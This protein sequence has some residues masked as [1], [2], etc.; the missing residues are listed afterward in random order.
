MNF[1]VTLKIILCFFCAIILHS[2][3]G[4]SKPD[5]FYDEV[6]RKTTR[7]YN[8]DKRQGYAKFYLDSVFQANPTPSSYG[9]FIYYRCKATWAYFEMKTDSNYAYVDSMHQVLEKNHLEQKYPSLYAN[10]LN[11]KGDYYFGQNDLAKSFEYYSQGKVV[12]SRSKDS[13]SMSDQNYHMGMVTYRQEK[14]TDA[15]QHFK[16]AMIFIGPCGQNEFA[17]YRGA[18]L[19]GNIGLAYTHVKNYDSALAYYK[20]AIDLAMSGSR[21]LNT[22]GS[23]KYAVIASGVQYGNMAKVYIAKNMKDSAEQL[24]LKSIVINDRP[25][26]DHIDALYAYMQLAELYFSDKQLPLTVATLNKI[27]D[28][29]IKL[30]DNATRREIRLRWLHLNYLYNKT[31]ADANGAIGYLE[32]YQALKDTADADAKVLKQTDYG[33][34]L[35][36]KEAQY[37]IDLLKRDNA[38]NRIYLFVAIGWVCIILC[39]IGLVYSNYR[40]SKKNVGILTELNS[41]ISQQKNQLEQAMYQLSESNNDKDRI[42]YIVAHDLRNPISAMMSMI[43]FMRED[44]LPDEHDEMLNMMNTAANV[45]MNL[46]N[47]LLQFSSNSMERPAGKKESADINALVANAVSLLKI[48]ADEKKQHISLSLS[49]T[50]APVLTEPEKLSRVFVNVLSNAIKFSMQATTIHISVTCNHN[51]VLIT[52]KDSGTGIPEADKHTIFQAFTNA[53]RTGTS[54]ERSFGI[55]LSICKQIVEGAGGKIWF[56][57]EEGRGTTFFIDLPLHNAA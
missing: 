35:K 43:G 29:L 28:R 38:F 37:Q 47:E 17:L 53:R 27:A 45:S 5:G 9:K 32:A 44:E 15:I 8:D 6:V 57:S 34:L 49:P 50:P 46:I 1:Q 11:A 54:G 48:K 7:L 39:V 25:T 20:S 42:L 16:D 33:Q 22:E 4:K 21:K 10:T 2:C 30:E 40:K 3:T 51:T 55:G 41:R 31:I 52:T 23:L 36:V 18:E 26:F 13:C 14:Y 24:L 19:L 56:E 12:A